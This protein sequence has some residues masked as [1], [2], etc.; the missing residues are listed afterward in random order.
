MTDFAWIKT[1]EI[2]TFML[3]NQDFANKTISSFFFFFLIVE[4]YLLVI[5]AKKQKQEL[6]YIQ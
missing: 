6:K 4:A 5:Q 2:K 3:F 1:L